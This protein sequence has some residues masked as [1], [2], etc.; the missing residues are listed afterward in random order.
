MP[1]HFSRYEAQTSVRDDPDIIHTVW[2]TAGQFLWAL[3][4]MR[5]GADISWPCPPHWECFL[6]VFTTIYTRTH[7]AN[8]ICCCMCRYHAHLQMVTYPA[9]LH[10]HTLYTNL[11]CCRWTDQ[12]PESVKDSDLL[13]LNEH[14]RQLS[15]S[16]KRRPSLFERTLHVTSRI[17]STHGG[18]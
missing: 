1:V 12:W 10:Y 18:N 11:A 5:S 4:K 7:T 8:R 13:S 6:I 15:L 3:E 2:F 14:A 16:R 9:S 17:R